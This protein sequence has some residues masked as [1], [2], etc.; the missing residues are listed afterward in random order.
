MSKNL[1]SF[2]FALN[3]LYC[4]GI[5]WEGVTNSVHRAIKDAKKMKNCHYP[6]GK[7]YTCMS[8]HTSSSVSKYVLDVNKCNTLK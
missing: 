3:Y 5:G 7:C 6:T 2:F 1:F 4:V 8:T